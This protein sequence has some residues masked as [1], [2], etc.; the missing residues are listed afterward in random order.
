MRFIKA[1]D[2]PQGE[3][4]FLKKSLGSWVVV[5]PLKKSDGSWNWFNLIVGS[6]NNLLMILFI[7]FMLS[8]QLFLFNQEVR[9]IENNYMKIASNP[10][11]W[12]EDVIA[13]KTNPFEYGYQNFSIDQE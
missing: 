5:H 2:L 1:E 11:T 12:C 8:S 6:W 13:G 3:E 10:I 7:I 4:V 9:V